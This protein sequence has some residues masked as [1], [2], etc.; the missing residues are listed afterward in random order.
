[1]LLLSE[2]EAEEADDDEEEDGK[3]E[4][5]DEDKV[6]EESGGSA[7][8]P[9]AAE[10]RQHARH[11]L[12]GPPPPRWS[13]SSSTATTLAAAS[14]NRSETVSQS[15]FC[16]MSSADVDNLNAATHEKQAFGGAARL[17]DELS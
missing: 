15:R 4:D 12:G 10:W 3:G 5:E 2:A 1:M 7:S 14:P 11:H 13:R 17:E 16:Q 9:Y 6:G 8:E